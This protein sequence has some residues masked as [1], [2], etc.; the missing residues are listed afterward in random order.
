[1][2]NI[3]HLGERIRLLPLNSLKVVLNTDE[4]RD[5]Y[6]T[7]EAN[8]IRLLQDHLITVMPYKV[9]SKQHQLLIIR[10][11]DNESRF[12]FFSYVVED[13]IDKISYEILEP[14]IAPLNR[15]INRPKRIVTSFIGRT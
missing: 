12:R 13:T 3:Y 15:T 5:T 4:H 8:G 6:Y 9:F 14:W 2:K 1:M 11:G 10:M 7:E